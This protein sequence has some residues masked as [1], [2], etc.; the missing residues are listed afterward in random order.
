[1]SNINNSINKKLYNRNL[2]S[3][4]GNIK[5]TRWPSY[6]DYL[7][8]NIGDEL[9]LDVGCGKG[10]YLPIFNNGIGIDFLIENVEKVNSAGLR[11]I[12]GDINDN[13]PFR[14]ESFDFIFC[15]HVIE[16]VKSPLDLLLECNRILKT[17]GRLFLVFPIENSIIRRY[18]DDFFEGH[19]SHLY[20]F[21]PS[22]ITRLLDLANF[23]D[24]NMRLTF[25]FS[26]VIIFKLIE[27]IISIN[28]N[29]FYHFGDSIY[30][31]C[32]K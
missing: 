12:R 3:N 26:N 14:D 28:P 23:R 4:I 5:K 21:T 19:S 30:I 10:D 27:D 29:I 32:F 1:M 15:S 13:L 25:P 6:I 7:I 22:G 2:E 8:N 11:I 24:L 20:S 18:Y 17:N 31:I 16:H 9:V